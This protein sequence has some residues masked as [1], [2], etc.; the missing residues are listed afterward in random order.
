MLRC[1]PREWNFDIDRFLNPFIP[2]PPWKHLPYPIAH[3]FG[4]RKS[5]PDNVGNL[6]PIFWACI[7]V[8]C[9]VAVVAL[10]S[11]QIP[12]FKEHGAPIIVGSFG[13]AAVLEFYSIESPLAQPRNSVFGQVLAAVIGVAICKLLQ[14]SSH[15][16]SVRWLGGALS[17]ALATTVMALTKTV[18]PPAG[19]T[20]LLA[21]VDDGVVRLGWILVPTVTL[22]CVIML[23]VALVINNIQR[24]FPQYW[25]SPE[26]VR[27]YRVPW[28]RR[29]GDV[30]SKGD[31]S[32]DEVEARSR[33]DSTVR[34][35]A[36][37]IMRPGEVIVPEH[38]FIT[39]EEKMFL[40]ELSNRL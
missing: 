16:E 11:R 30:E 26:D 4:Y 23:V 25:W 33:S 31:A 5:K 24:R 22:G 2:P 36:V 19:A 7:G 1:N 18:H 21:V 6:V 40:E 12:I 29:G 37:L 27:V 10:V 38:M 35:D 32:S 3:I 39:P 8:F 17:C 34:E 15:F 9:G 13:A 14:L 20:A 28:R